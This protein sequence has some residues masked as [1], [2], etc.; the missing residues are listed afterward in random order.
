MDFIHTLP[1]ELLIKIIQTLPPKL[2]YT[3]LPLLD[4]RFHGICRNIT[5]GIQLNVR[6]EFNDTV[7]C[8]TPVCPG[9][10][11]LSQNL[12][13]CIF[14]TPAEEWC[15]ACHTFRYSTDWGRSA[16]RIRKKTRKRDPVRPMT[17]FGVKINLCIPTISTFLT[18]LQP[19]ESSGNTPLYNELVKLLH[20]PH[21][22]LYTHHF[23]TFGEHFPGE[24]V[25]ST[26]AST[27]RKCLEMLP[28]VEH[29]TVSCDILACGALPAG[30]IKD[31]FL[32][33]DHF[34]DCN[35]HR[36]GTFH[37]LE[38]LELIQKI[39]ADA[40]ALTDWGWI[41][42]HKLEEL[43]LYAADILR[44]SASD[45]LLRVLGE[46]PNLTVLE[47][48]VGIVITQQ[49]DV[50]CNLKSLGVVESPTVEVY[51]SRMLSKVVDLQ[52]R[53]RSIN[54][55]QR[56]AVCRFS[57]RLQHLTVFITQLSE[58][59]WRNSYHLLKEVAQNV[60]AD[61]HNIKSLELLAH[62]IPAADLAAAQRILEGAISEVRPNESLR[63]LTVGTCPDYLGTYD[64][65]GYHH[66]S[67]Q[68]EYDDADPS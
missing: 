22:E 9:K 42:G 38:R 5:V 23:D 68:H 65:D 64:N 49:A 48:P 50:E 21:L 17:G 27:L 6:L 51:S 13:Y 14:V 2:L 46:R 44:G 52:I 56:L 62:R 20:I 39:D 55:L 11:S 3:T 45:N 15:G 67:V 19:S 61:G 16:G 18:S 37:H 24:E 30:K 53:L 60:C 40:D 33:V 59:K 63:N 41:I 7:Y 25:F 35:L 31:L 43:V 54:E 66:D 8:D 4:K 10:D 57:P 32:V 29:S 26:I 47:A 1:N 12:G 28:H 58:R 36:K 34:S